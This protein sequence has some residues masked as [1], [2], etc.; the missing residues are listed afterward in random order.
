[1]ERKVQ[2]EWLDSLSPD[3]PAA[4]RNRRDL[5]VLNRIIGTRRWFRT[6]LA[7]RARPGE[8]VL[9]IGAGTGDLARALQARGWSVDGLDPWPAP[10][11]WPAGQRWHRAD[12]REFDR[13]GD[14]EVVIGNLIFH[15]FTAPELRELGRRISHCRVLLAAEPARLRR[16]QWFLAAGGLLLGANEVTKHDGRVSIEGGFLGDELPRFLALERAAWSWRVDMPRLGMY[17]LSAERP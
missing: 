6:E 7:R 2:P 3:D 13:F 10:P 1:M 16:A 9:E 15:Q 12:A 8:R 4:V 5:R 14:Y 17:R 11:D